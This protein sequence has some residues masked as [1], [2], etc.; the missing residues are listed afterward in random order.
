MKT[1][2]TCIDKLGDLVTLEK[3]S[4]YLPWKSLISLVENTLDL[5]AFS[6]R[7]TEGVFVCIKDTVVSH[8]T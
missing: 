5:F 1:P 6:Q 2:V 4:F 8:G 3:L 7:K